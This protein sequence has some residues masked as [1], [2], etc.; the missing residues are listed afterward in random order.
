MRPSW[1]HVGAI[2]RSTSST[3]RSPSGPSNTGASPMQSIQRRR[4]TKRVPPTVCGQSPHLVMQAITRM[5][6][7]RGLYLNNRWKR[8]V[9]ELLTDEDD[10]D[11][12]NEMDHDHWF[13]ERNC[14]QVWYTFGKPVAVPYRHSTRAKSRRSGYSQISLMGMICLWVGHFLPRPAVFPTGIQLAA[15]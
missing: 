9:S 14:V 13:E 12:D 3:A 11:E 1:S 10:D 2:L 15:L 5:W 8:L 7:L 6:L 4:Q